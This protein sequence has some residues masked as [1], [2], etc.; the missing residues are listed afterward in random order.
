MFGKVTS[1]NHKLRDDTV[2]ARS[3]VTIFV[4][5]SSEFTEIFCSSWN[6]VIVELE[7]DSSFGRRAIIFF[8]L[9]TKLKTKLW[10]IDWLKVYMKNLQKRLTWLTRDNR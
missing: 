2:E 6:Y 10:G 5:S 7:D 1:L 8:Y 3:L 4:L 9:N